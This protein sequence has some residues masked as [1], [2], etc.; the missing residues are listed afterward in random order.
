[1]IDLLKSHQSIRKYKNEPISDQTFHQM[2][3]A[4]QHAASSNFIQAYSVIQVK[5]EEKKRELGKLSRNELQFE[6]AALSLVFCADLNRAAQAVQQEGDEIQGGTTEN[7]LVATIDTALVAQN[8]VIAAESKG[9]GICYIGGVRNNPKQ[10]SEL[11]SLSHYVTPLFGMTV[12]VPDEKNEVKPRQSVETIIHEDEY[13]S[14]KYVH[15]LKEYD[16][17]MSEYYNRR[18]S[19]KKEITWSQSMRDFLTDARRPFLKEFIMSQGFLRD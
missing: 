7:F 15:Q 12:G 9:Y 14:E 6:T 2:L 3:H 16:Q 5:D 11:F 1:M 19:N 10:I 8:F 18:T 4:A 17:I 13:D